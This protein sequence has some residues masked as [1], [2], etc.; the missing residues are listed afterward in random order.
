MPDSDQPI[1]LDDWDDADI[2]EIY[3]PPREGGWTY[4]ALREFREQ[5]R[6]INGGVSRTKTLIVP[7]G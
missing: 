3:L 5:R 2:P 7:E 6:R 4:E 1:E